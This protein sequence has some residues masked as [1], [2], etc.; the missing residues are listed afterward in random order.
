LSYALS[1]DTVPREIPS[2][3]L[4]RAAV[5]A[6]EKYGTDEWLRRR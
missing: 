3:I 6:T 4:A 2:S 5:L 1:P